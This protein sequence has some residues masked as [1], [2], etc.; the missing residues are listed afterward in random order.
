MNRRTLGVVVGV[1]ALAVA[2]L[3]VWQ[4]QSGRGNPAT[5][6]P[7]GE[8]SSRPG[9]AA[10]NRNAEPIRARGASLTNRSS[11]VPVDQAEKEISRLLE[12]D[13]ISNRQASEKLLAIAADPLMAKEMRADALGHGLNLVIDEEFAELVLPY[14]EENFFEDAEMKRVALDNAYNREDMA[15][16][17]AALA[18]FRHGEGE[19]RREARDL[20][21]FILDQDGDAFGDDLEAWKRAIT[22]HLNRKPE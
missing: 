20:M 2:L 10:S 12:D 11:G 4:S 16:L 14:L 1:C 17:P 21:E 3:I 19:L 6:K 9:S 18:L 15:K 13:T 7:A 5:K 8:M 22:E